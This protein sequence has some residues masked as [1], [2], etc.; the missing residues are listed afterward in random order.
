MKRVLMLRYGG[1]GDSMAITPV[2][3]NYKDRN[4][5]CEIHFGV[6]G[7]DQVSLYENLPYFHRVFEIFRF[8]D[9]HDGA[10]CAK[11]KDGYEAMEYHKTKYDL[12][13]DF[14]NLIEN[15]SMHHQMMEINGDW[16]KSMNSNYQNWIDLALSW[17]NIDPASV[18]DEDKILRYIVKD[19]EKEDAQ[20]LL[21]G[22]SENYDLLIGLNTLSSSRARS[23]FDL[24]SLIGEILDEIPRSVVIAWDSNRWVALTDS[25]GKEIVLNPSLR[26][27]A[28]ILSCFDAFV[29]TDSGFSHMAEA[30]GT[31]N[32]TIYTTIPGWTRNK[33]YNHV[34]PI[35]SSLPCSPCFT[36]M[37]NCPVNKKRALDS[38]TDRER[39]ILHLSNQNIS[40]QDA[41]KSLATT[42]DKVIMEHKALQEKINGLESVIPD[43]MASITPDMIVSRLKEVLV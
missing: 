24:D 33:Y 1:I 30:V 16:A 15:N 2:A 40:P 10:N 39:Q 32:V 9:P 29:S 12:V 8:P 43:C 7:K 41:A 19:K 34:L 11:V 23:Y 13:F 5:N 14:V 4:P 31:M 35:Q 28:A 38:I 37:E 18:E 6:R 36:L 42:P 25:G 20:L 17:V 21:S 27:S 22:I 3:Y 26:Q